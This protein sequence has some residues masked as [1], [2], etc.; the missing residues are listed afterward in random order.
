[1]FHAGI[2]A[3]SSAFLLQLLMPPPDELPFTGFDELELMS[4]NLEGL[5]RPPIACD[6]E[7][8]GVELASLVLLAPLCRVALEFPAANPPVLCGLTTPVLPFSPMILGN[9]LGCT[10][11]ALRLK[12]E[13]HCRT[14]AGSFDS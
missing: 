3:P 1:M 4:E 2:V 11:F 14:W 9:V 6:A 13:I 10:A 8:D 7:Y 12:A 5:P